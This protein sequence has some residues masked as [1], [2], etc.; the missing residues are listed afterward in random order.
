MIDYWPFIM[1]GGGGTR[2]WPKSRQH[3]PKQFLPIVGDKAMITQTTDRLESGCSAEKIFIITNEKQAAGTR[4][5]VPAIPAEN[6]IAE[7]LG[8]N[9]A[10]CVGI[11]AVYAREKS[12][13]DP[14]IGIF[15]ADHV[16]GPIDEFNKTVKAAAEL[17]ETP[18]NIVTIGIKPTFPSTG[19]GY[20]E[21]GDNIAGSDVNSFDVKRFTE[22]PG[23]AAAEEFVASGNFSWNAGIFFFKSGTVLAELERQQPEIFKRVEEFSKAIGT[24]DE[25]KALEKCYNDMPSISFDYAVMEGAE[26]IKVVEA[27]FNWDDVGSW[28][29]IPRHF[30]KDDGNNLLRGD[31]VAIDSSNCHVESS[32]MVALVGV[33]NL[34]IVET[35]DAVLIC[36]SSRA[37]EVK[38]IVETLKNEGREELL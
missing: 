11:A 23:L 6:V 38:K 29:A 34:T 2:F 18:G 13:G 27:T 36:E 28:A 37:E 16:I 15:S 19:Y 5:L 9:T 10:P 21:H 12:G 24:A 17:A 32:R 7:P 8:R 4:E 31:V 30:K 3:C 26:N 22:K 35:D 25:C 33:E 20:I 1:A 14:V